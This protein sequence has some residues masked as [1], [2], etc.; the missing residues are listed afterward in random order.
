L[1]IKKSESGR[2]DSTGIRRPDEVALFA[3]QS[4]WLMTRESGRLS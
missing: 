2:L 4:G 1:Q 3:T